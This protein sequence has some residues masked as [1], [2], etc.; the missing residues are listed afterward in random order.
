MKMKDVKK[1]K[2]AYLINGFLEAIEQ[3]CANI[4]WKG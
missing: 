1:S 2:I 4:V 3:W